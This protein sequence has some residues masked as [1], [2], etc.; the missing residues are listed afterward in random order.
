MIFSDNRFCIV[1]FFIKGAR[2]LAIYDFMA[3]ANILSGSPLCNRTFMAHYHHLSFTGHVMTIRCKTGSEG[4]DCTG[5][6]NLV[7]LLKVR[8]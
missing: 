1:F 8:H 2:A 6:D 4:V 7:I 3:I 5:W